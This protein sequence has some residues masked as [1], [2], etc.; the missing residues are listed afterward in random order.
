MFHYFISLLNLIIKEQNSV[1]FVTKTK[2][3]I[4]LLLLFYA[5]KFCILREIK[6]SDV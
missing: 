1:L 3:E 6:F 4:N 2:I 5:K